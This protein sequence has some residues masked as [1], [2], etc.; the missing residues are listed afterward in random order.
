MEQLRK[1]WKAT[2]CLFKKKYLYTVRK[3]GKKDIDWKSSILDDWEGKDYV[4]LPCGKCL[5]CQEQYSKQWAVRCMLEAKKYNGQCC[6]ITLT[7][8]EANVPKDGFLNKKDYQLFLKRLRRKYKGIKIRFFLA[9]E[10]GSKGLRPHFH[11]VLFGYKPSDLRDSWKD[12]KTTLWRS[13]EVE[14]LWGK[15]FISVGTTIEVSAIKYVAKYLTKTRIL[16]PQYKNHPEFIQA[17]TNPGIGYYE[18]DKEMLKD[19][20]VWL[21]GSKYSLPKY[22]KKLA[23]RFGYTEE[24]KE[25]Q[26]QQ[27]LMGQIT[28]KTPLELQKQRYNYY[29]SCILNK[30]GYTHLYDLRR[31]DLYQEYQEVK[32]ALDIM[33]KDTRIIY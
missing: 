17:S 22:Y 12:G 9:G 18:F 19:G 33:S 3:D 25:Y 15:G 29:Q 13:K 24:L 32:K 6:F 26:T 27:M 28:Q 8:N 23:E 21:L 4:Q 11:I 14:E 7:Y 16:P 31:Q 5:Y 1:E 20:G 30:I 10:Y 2:E